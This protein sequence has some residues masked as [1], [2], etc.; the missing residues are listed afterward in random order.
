MDYFPNQQCMREFCALTWPLIRAARA[1][2]TLTIVGASPSQEMKKLGELP[3]VTVTGT[4]P[5]VRPHVRRAAVNVATLK[6]AR[7]TQ[8]KILE[9]LAMGVPVVASEIAAGGVDVAPGEHLLTADTPR[10]IADQVLRLLNDPA[11]RHRMS[12]AGRTRMESN[13]S[14]DASLRKLDGLI[15]ECLTLPPAGGVKTVRVA[16]PAS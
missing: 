14:W 8:N 9:S 3:G 1:E 7:G 10:E 16:S 12:R 2:A 4:V 6:I 11:E 13:H 15:E 5:D